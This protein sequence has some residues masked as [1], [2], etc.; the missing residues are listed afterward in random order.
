VNLFINGFANLDVTDLFQF[1]AK[2]GATKYCGKNLAEALKL[3]C[4]GY[5][6]DPDIKKKSVPGKKIKVRREILLSVLIFQKL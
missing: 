3:V 2:R 6:F 4:A 5:Y 1:E